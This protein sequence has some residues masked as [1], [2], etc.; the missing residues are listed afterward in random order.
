MKKTFMVMMITAAMSLSVMAQSNTIKGK[1]DIAFNSR[2]QV[3]GA[4]NPVPG[5][6][7]V[8]TYDLGVTDLL[9]FQG[10]IEHLPTIMMPKVGIEKQS[11][12]LAYDLM[13]SIRNPKDI[14]QTKAIGK[15]VGV[16]PIDKNGVYRYDNGTLRMAV[17][18]SGAAAGFESS[19]RGLA[20]GKAPKNGSFIAET[21]KKAET[22][23]RQVQGKTVKIIVTDYDKMIFTD[24]VLGAGPVKAYPETR[25]NGEM[26]FDY[27]RSAWYFRNVSMTYV[28]AGKTITDKLSGH[29]KW[30]ES[31]QR[32]SNGEGEYQFDVRVNEPE[33]NNEAAVFQGG[34]DESAFFSV[35]NT[36]TSLT[37]KAK[38]KDQMR[39][40][41]VSASAITVDL[42]GNGLDKQQIVALTKLI[43]MVCVVPVNAE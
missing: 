2:V 36:L 23:T 43:W 6:K 22:F 34:D 33:K 42:V 21:K 11:S 16:V 1:I 12:S 7:D 4:G 32:K 19:F 39:G 41:T 24:L 9:I 40:E 29:I 18:A 8:Y 28:S 35:D 13:L 5:V 10:K 15:F 20:A 3:D 17:D 26:L 27:E 38:Y 31:P 30:V 25:V 14:T 37:G